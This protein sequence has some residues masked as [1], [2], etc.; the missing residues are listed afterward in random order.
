M[1]HWKKKNKQEESQKHILECSEILK[2]NGFKTVEYEQ[3]FEEDAKLQLEVVR[4]FIM[5]MKIKKKLLNESKLI[6]L[7]I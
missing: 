5:N 4:T 1:W 7:D 6:L 2:E 3:I